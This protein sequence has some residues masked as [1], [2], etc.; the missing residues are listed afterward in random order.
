MVHIY[1]CGV[2]SNSSLSFILAGDE[3]YNFLIPIMK[4]LVDKCH[5]MLDMSNLLPNLPSTQKSPTFFEDFKSYCRSEEWRIF[6]KKQVGCIC[7]LA[8]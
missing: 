6:M 7:H 8:Q 4:A 3:Q 2:L 5:D 1:V